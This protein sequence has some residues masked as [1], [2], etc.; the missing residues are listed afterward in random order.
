MPASRVQ[1]T[2]LQRD[3]QKLFGITITVLR[4]NREKTNLRFR[5][6]PGSL[7]VSS[8][9]GGNR[10]IG[11]GKDGSALYL[12][13]VIALVQRVAL[14]NG[15]P[16]DRPEGHKLTFRKSLSGGFGQWHDRIGGFRCG[17]RLRFRHG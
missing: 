8:S 2:L 7:S 5:A 9:H 12:L 1:G 11:Q 10:L 4:Q 3:V 6:A 17:R 14:E 15:P 13:R 16:I